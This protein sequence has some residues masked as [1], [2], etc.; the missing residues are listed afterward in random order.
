VP[1]YR[2][3]LTVC[4]GSTQRA[5]LPRRATTC[6]MH[7][8]IQKRTLRLAGPLETSCRPWGGFWM[9]SGCHP[10]GDTSGVWL[11]VSMWLSAR[12]AA[13]TG[14]GT[15]THLGLATHVP[16]VAALCRTVYIHSLPRSVGW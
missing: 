1:L 6:R 9:V 16:H 12:R 3:E 10:A 7:S 13:P 14:S 8:P 15:G 11:V 4:A 5:L 2:A